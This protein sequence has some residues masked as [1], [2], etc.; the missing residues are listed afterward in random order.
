MKLSRGGARGTAAI[1]GGAPGSSD[2]S[3]TRSIAIHGVNTN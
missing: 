1:G 3:G 2:Q